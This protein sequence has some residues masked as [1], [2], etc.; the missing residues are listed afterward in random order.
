MQKRTYHDFQKAKIHRSY[1]RRSDGSSVQGATTI[2]GNCAWGNFFLTRW[3]LNE[4]RAGR[5]PQKSM[6]VAGEIGTLTHYLIEC[7]LRGWEPELGEYGK[8]FIDAA[9]KNFE[10]FKKWAKRMQFKTHEI[11]LPIA[12][13]EFPYGGT[14]DLIC[15]VQGEKFLG[16][17]KTSKG[18]YPKQEMQ[19]VA[20]AKAYEEVHGVYLP[21]CFL[22]I[23]Q[24]RCTTEWVDD[25]RVPVLW[26]A[27]KALLVVNE[28]KKKLGA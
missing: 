10:G 8:D 26:E 27:F 18:I 19:V 3:Q 28:C 13:E 15:E 9:T 22:H 17:V 24:G 1:P 16:D 25:D 14:I 11:E 2:I 5:D 21:Q 4:M 20:Y 23:Y 6:E 7:Y 12:S